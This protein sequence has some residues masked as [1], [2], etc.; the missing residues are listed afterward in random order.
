MNAP[1]RQP[2]LKPYCQS[3]LRVEV[4]VVVSLAEK[5][6]RIDQILKLVPGVMLQFNKPCTAPMTVEVGDQ[7]IAHGD[8]V[9]V[10]DKFGIRITEILRPRERFIAITGRAP[11]PTELPTSAKT[12][13]QPSPAA[14]QSSSAEDQ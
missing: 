7:P 12:S 1:P 11:H 3:V 8:V 9:K 5:K 13:R 2:L 14:P 4:P 6:M 10:G